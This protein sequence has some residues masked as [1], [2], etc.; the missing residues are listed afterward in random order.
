MARLR[1]FGKFNITQGSEA[2]TPSAQLID[3]V[4]TGNHGFC[5]GLTIIEDAASFDD[6][7]KGRLIR[8]RIA[9][10]AGAVR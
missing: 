1:R 6:S 8:I 9:A 7:L 5:P 3:Q 10:D 4:H 2:E